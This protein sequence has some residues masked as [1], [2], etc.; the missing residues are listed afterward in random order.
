M[1]Y[2]YDDVAKYPTKFE[3]ILKSPFPEKLKFYYFDHVFDTADWN[4]EPAE[5]LPTLYKRR[6]EFLRDTYDYLVLCYSGGI[7]STT[8]LE[9]FYDNNIHIDEIVLVGAFSQ[10]AS[11][12]SDE[13]HNLEIY[14][15]CFPLLNK[16][17]LKNTVVNVLDYTK[18]FGT[19]ENFTISKYG[20]MWPI[21]TGAYFSVHN[22]FWYDIHK[23]LINKNLNNAGIIF[24]AG[25]PGIN[26]NPFS[27]RFSDKELLG[28]C[29]LNNIEARGLTR[30]NFYTDP[31][32]IDLQVKQF[33]V[34]RNIFHNTYN[35]SLSKTNKFI[36]EC[37]Y[38]L[39]NPLIHLSRKSPDAFLSIR[40]TYVI[41][42]KNSRMFNFF[43]S[44]YLQ[45][46]KHGIKS[47]F[48]TSIQSKSYGLTK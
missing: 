9:T 4:K 13:N 24:G 25:K 28:P 10:D 38:D 5:S 47:F 37:I 2:Y 39:K 48:N 18:Y 29:G 33:N 42:H 1:I 35:F 44:G 16:L 12:E 36:E 21:A 7:D 26:F 31:T 45:A 30:I 27:I 22:F 19:E 20:N 14:K 40:D 11:T 34:I 41:K 32:T 17:E 15:N 43:K 3:A 6:A 23:Y 46:H 8:I